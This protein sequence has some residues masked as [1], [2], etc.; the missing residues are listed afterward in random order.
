MQHF[1]DLMRLIAA[2]AHLAPIPERY[3]LHAAW[4]HLHSRES[5]N[6]ST[7]IA[8]ARNLLRLERDMTARPQHY[9]LKPSWK[10]DWEWAEIAPAT[11]PEREG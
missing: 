9:R 2:K 10:T 11:G 8:Y 1:R 5:K 6:P 4:W 7:A 3:R